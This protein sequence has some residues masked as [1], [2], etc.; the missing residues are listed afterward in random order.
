MYI[1]NDKLRI[2]ITMIY[3]L[4]DI[5]THSY[6]NEILIIV[7]LGPRGRIVKH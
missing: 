3:I 6:H 1:N 5:E 7:A 2:L 4:G